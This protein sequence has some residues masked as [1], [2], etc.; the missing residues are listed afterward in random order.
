MSDADAHKMFKVNQ[1]GQK[2]MLK[3]LF[4]KVKPGIAVEAVGD[5]KVL[6]QE[7]SKCHGIWCVPHICLGLN[8]AEFVH[9]QMMKTRIFEVVC[10]SNDAIEM[11][12]RNQ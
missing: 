8:R 10:S 7:Y 4:V 9:V 6:D 5:T 1:Y 11:F 2:N 12:K 3:V